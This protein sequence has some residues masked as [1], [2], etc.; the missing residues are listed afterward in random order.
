MNFFIPV[1]K[2]APS[3]KLKFKSPRV[4][5]IKSTLLG[6]EQV[7]SFYHHCEHCHLISLCIS[8]VNL[9]TIRLTMRGDPGDTLGKS[10]IVPIF[11]PMDQVGTHHCTMCCLY[12]TIA[13]Y[14]KPQIQK[15]LFSSETIIF[16]L[17]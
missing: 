17:F 7:A 4:K 10:P 1:F 15:P 3:P 8:C 11:L 13:L 6:L 16:G 14:P 9:K 5:R 12:C 2:A